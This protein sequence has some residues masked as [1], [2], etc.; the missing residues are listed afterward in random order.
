MQSERAGRGRAERL[1]HLGLDGL[2]FFLAIMQTG[3]GAF[4]PAY[5]TLQGWSQTQIGFAL[6]VNTVGSIISQVPG[7]AVVDVTRHRRR[8]FAL[9]TAG[10]STAALVLAL[11]PVYG[12]V[13]LAMLLQAFASSI[14]TP[15]IAAISLMLV[16][17]VALGERLGRNVRFA[18][19]G[20]ALGAALM[21]LIASVLSERAVF[22]LAAALAVPVLL[23]L[24]C[25]SEPESHWRPE[26]HGHFPEHAEA[27]APLLT[28][29]R[30]PR[31]L[32]FAA[33]V[34]LFH[35]SSAAIVPLAVGDMA[36]RIGAKGGW[37]VA[38]FIVV[39]QIVVAVA[40][41][42]VGRA[43]ERYGRRPV[44]LLGFCAL[45]LRG[46]L[47]A[48]V[49]DPAVLVMVQVLEGVAAAVFGVML[50]L[51]TADLTRRTGRYNLMLGFLGL[52]VAAGAAVSTALAGAVADVFDLATA[53][54]MLGGFGLLSVALVGGVMQET[55]HT[56]PRRALAARGAA[57]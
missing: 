55:H 8:L 20:G 33:C 6:S 50:P 7:G 34:V 22:L 53:Y 52:A 32:A 47:F 3:F 41:P 14:T 28:L 24:R 18:A 17:H 54:W 38:A 37:L 2:N 36:R 51:V 35:I 13:L 9:A 30:D 4:V 5:L 15:A 49:R 1:C 39:P 48:L 42:A 26:M 46:A 44:L 21:G 31:L 16:G 23:T 29:L 19:I 25:I 56:P 57:E 11:L 43:A 27:T 45:P 40:S 10:L 12:P